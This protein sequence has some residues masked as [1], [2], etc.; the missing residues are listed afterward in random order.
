MSHVNV[1][2]IRLLKIF[3]LQY[4]ILSFHTALVI[5]YRIKNYPSKK[6]NKDQYYLSFTYRNNCLYVHERTR[7]RIGYGWSSSIAAIL[8]RCSLPDRT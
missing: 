7:V 4:Y 1:N 8:V 3:V 2:K 5:L 6:R